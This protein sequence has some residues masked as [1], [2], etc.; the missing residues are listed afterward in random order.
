[1][2]NQNAEDDTKNLPTEKYLGNGIKLN[3]RLT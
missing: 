1:M 2:S 3:Y